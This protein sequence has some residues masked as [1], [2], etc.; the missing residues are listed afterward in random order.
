M[1]LIGRAAQLD[2]IAAAL[3]DGHSVRVA[4]ARGTG[5]SAVLAAA[6][7]RHAA[8]GVAVLAV[9]AL[10]GDRSL[11]GAGLQRLLTPVQHETRALPPAAVAAFAR[12]FG[13]DAPDVPPA[14]LPE[15]V[16]LL[17]EHLAGRGRRLW[18]ADDLDRLD[19][20]S[21]TVIVTQPHIPV[22]AA[23]LAPSTA[24][25]AP[26]PPGAGLEAAVTV[27][28]GRLSRAEAE[29][30]LAGLPGVRAHPAARLLTAQAAGN[31]LALTEL[32]R[33]LPPAAEIPPTATELPVPSRLRRALAPAVDTL[34]P[35]HLRAAVLAAVAAETPGRRVAAA[36]AGAAEPAV[37]AGLAGAGV[38]RPGRRFRHPVI[39]AAV[40]ERAG[41]ARRRAARRE[42]AARLP[43]GDPARAWHLARADPAPDESRA[44]V[45]ERA[46]AHLNRAGRVHAATYA[47]AMAAAVSPDPEHAR[48]RARL[49]AHHARLAGE[50][51]WERQLAPAGPREPR[52]LGHLLRTAWLRGDDRIRAEVRSALAATGPSPA[53]PDAA[54]TA[55]L[56]TA[57]AHA[58]VD[59]LDPTGRV[60][61]LINEYD[62]PGPA[63]RMSPAERAVALGTMAQARHETGAARR[64]LARVVTLDPP[65]GLLRP[66]ALG[67]LAW[68]DYDAADLDGA[69]AHAREALR[70]TD[71]DRHALITTDTRA[72]A[73]ATLA[74]V[75][76]LREQP[77]AADRLGA[78]R[79]ALQPGR[80]ALHDLRL[81][82]AQ[83]L[84]AGIRG[85]HELA[86]HRLRRHY[87]RAG[88]PVHHRVAAL[89]LADLAL[90][91]VAVDRT[92]EAAA[93]VTAA[94]PGVRALRSARLSAIWHR[95][96]ALLAGPDPAAETFFR[97]A[98]ADPATDQWPFE[99]AL[100]RM[101]YAQ[102]LR[103]RQRP[104]ESRPLLRAARDVFAAAGLPAWRER[105]EAELA[106]AAAPPRPGGAPG[107][108]LTPQQRQVVAL[109]AQGLTNARIAARLG[110]SAR[111]VGTHLSRAYSILGVKRRAQLP[112]VQSF[113]GRRAAGG[114]SR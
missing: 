107:G 11:P 102:W 55:D 101:D 89:C 68:A 66:I 94:E 72:G 45:L 39:R 80:H 112:S 64:H 81:D 97:L 36:L 96:R 76:V 46:G 1:T 35:V 83:G 50:P 23:T 74:A 25:P 71:A 40:L 20:L 9:R 90:V 5:R 41:S 33:H 87:D 17:A 29:R 16:S 14:P 18:C 98:L 34:D 37:W 111:T 108:G 77:D 12:L 109:A 105:A 10:P 19:A 110:L 60:H 82:R 67:A 32:A 27:D 84:I 21:R 92:G 47:L 57:W 6:A 54:E 26:A 113:D 85:E 95:A 8:T 103:R 99:R 48:I 22:L 44:A 53:H 43:A 7:A 31:P 114:P 13:A 4:G 49:A 56:L 3:R 91:A 28:L 52:G 15:A 65:G 42:L 104:A 69:L 78:A 75:A 106:A 2:Q 79:D 73:L 93:V 30:L 70:V 100:A 59:D 61:Q 63:G 24:H 51:A 58:V 88:R 62:R 38:L 86:F